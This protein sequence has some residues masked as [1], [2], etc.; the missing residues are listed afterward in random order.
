MQSQ[1]IQ[2]R[3]EEILA[4]NEEILQQ[5]EQI[6]SQNKLLSDK[7]LLITSSI[8]Y[9][10]NIQQAL[11]AKEEELKKALPDSFIFY[12]PRDIVSGDFYWVREL[13]FKERS[14]AGR[15]YWLQ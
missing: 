10:R 3:N 4:Q 11:L 2:Q 14:P 5:Q 6:A 8:N 1:V 7:N 13:G 12:L 15:T 9:A